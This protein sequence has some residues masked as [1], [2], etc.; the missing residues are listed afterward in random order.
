MK[1]LENY[2]KKHGLDYQVITYKAQGQKVRRKGYDLL[3][4][5][6]FILALEPVQYRFY[7][8]KYLIRFAPL[9]YDGPLRINRIN[10]NSLNQI[11]KTI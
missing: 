7:P 4:N 6:R 3:K 9:G 1:T 10:Q 2:C 11:L 8:E 5:G